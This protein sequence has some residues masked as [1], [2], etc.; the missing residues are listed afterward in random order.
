MTDCVPTREKSLRTTSARTPREAR[1][2]HL[3]SL[4]TSS[5]T[6]FAVCFASFVVKVFRRGVLTSKPAT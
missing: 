3:G 6:S 1:D 5:F 4:V 2:K